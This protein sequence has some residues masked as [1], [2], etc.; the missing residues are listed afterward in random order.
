MEDLTVSYNSSWFPHTTFASVSIAILCMVHAHSTSI[1]QVIVATAHVQ[2]LQ[3]VGHM[4]TERNHK[5][6][7][8]SR[9]VHCAPCVAIEAFT[10]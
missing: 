2:L 5:S 10:H 3:V 7:A 1:S 9:F 4:A 6:G 8:V